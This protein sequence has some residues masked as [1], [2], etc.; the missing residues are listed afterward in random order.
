MVLRPS[1]TPG[2][3]PQISGSFA[4]GEPLS[5]MTR[6]MSDACPASRSARA[7]PIKVPPV[8]TPAQ[9]PWTVPSTS[10]MSSGPVVRCW[11][12]ALSGFS[13]WRGRKIRGSFAAISRVASRAPSTPRSPLVKTTSPP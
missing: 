1:T 12:S 5:G 11:A 7:M 4:R 10:A 8:P 6:A 13:N 3:P 2:M 9:K